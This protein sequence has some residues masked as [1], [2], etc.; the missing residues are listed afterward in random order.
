MNIRYSKLLPIITFISDLI[1]LNISIQFAHL[2][3]FNYFSNEITSSVFLLLVNMAWISIASLTKNYVIQRPLVL[4]NSINRILSSLIY[5]SVAVLGV[6]YFF[7]FYE[8]SRWEMLFTYLLFFILIVVERSLIFA[9]LDYIRKKG[10]NIKHILIIGNE[11]IARR[12]KSSFEKQPEYGYNFVGNITE[13]SLSKMTRQ[14]LFDKIIK[15]EVKEVFICYRAL[16]QSLL[17]SIVDFGDQNAIKIKFVSDLVLEN[18]SATIINYKSFPVIQLSNSV[19]LSLKI[20]VFKRCFDIL[21]SL[22]VMIPGLPVFILLM[23]ITK[24]TSKGP[25]FYAQERIG[26]NNKPFKIYKFRSMYVNSELLGPQ[27]S[28]D[29]DPRITKWGRVIRKSRLDELPQFW[30][31]LKGDMS[32]VGPRP[33]RQ[34]FIEQLIERSPNY[35]KLLRLKPGLTSMGQVNYGYAENVDQMCNRVRYDL[36]YL[37]NINLNSEIGVILKTIR[38]MTQLKGK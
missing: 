26:R 19:E 2:L 30:N 23:I 4:S 13:E 6:V 12:V 3:V 34:F 18:S 38:V 17:K 9:G 14:M 37:N 15:T 35:K 32:I 16:D 29:H 11:D 10:F 33:E 36:L 27:L 1:I 28:S 21:F 25:V 8:V 31:V 24:L 22:F 7:K 5:H 20:V